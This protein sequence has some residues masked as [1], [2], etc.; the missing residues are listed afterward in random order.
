MPVKTGATAADVARAAGRRAVPRRRRPRGRRGRADPARAALALRRLRGRRPGAGRRGRRP[1]RARRGRG[2]PPGRRPRRQG[3]RRRSRSNLVFDT[4]LAAYLLDPARRGFP[5]DELCEERGLAVTAEDE[6]AAR[7]V[8][9]H[10]LAAQQREQLDER[11]LTDL[12]NDIE[13]PLVHV[14]REAEK[15]GIKLDTKRLEEA[16]TRDPRP[17]PSSSSA[18]SGSMAGEE[19]MIGS[20]QQLAEVLFVKLGL[21]RKRRGKTGFST[22]ARV[23]QAIRDEHPIIP[24]IE[25]FREL[26]KLV[27]TYL[28]AL[29]AWIGDDG[30][31][32]TTFLQTN[33]ATGPA[34]VDQPE[35]PEHP[36]P[37]RDRARDPPLLRRRA[38][39]RADLGRLRAGRAARARPHR[40]RAGAAR[41]LPA[42]RGRPH[43]DRL[44]GLRAAA[45]AA[46]RRHALE[47]QDGQLRDRLRPRPPTASPTACRSRRRRRRSSSTAT[48]SASR[49]SRSS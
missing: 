18:R 13:L 9:V 22:D 34:R 8:L 5:L 48:S 28:D 31:L 7:A 2:R 45:R 15:V 35:P 19:F 3:A 1:G 14:L 17:T 44:E 43:R 6:N 40:R 26:T 42:R 21:S 38:R 39:Q 47:G 33:A 4:E 25:R 49:P 36:D 27:Q 29:P 11:G 20:P 23:L 16:A 32:H 41:H 37:H 24:K 46:R 12:L 10:D 30:R